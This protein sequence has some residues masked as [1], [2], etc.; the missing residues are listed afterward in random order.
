ML[1]LAVAACGGGQPEPKNEFFSQPARFAVEVHG[2][3]TATFNGEWRLVVLRNDG[4]EDYRLLVMG[5]DTPIEAPGWTIEAFVELVDFKGE[6]RYQAL[7]PIGAGQELL[8]NHA[9]VQIVE[10][11]AAGSPEAFRYERVVKP[12]R[13]QISREGAK[14]SAVCD[15]LA[16]D[17]EGKLV[18]TLR[19]SWEG[20]GPR[21]EITPEPTPS[22]SPVSPASPSPS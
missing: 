16:A 4:P 19:M 6:G 17:Q 22:G 13:F 11:G 21:R 1:A 14:G 15:G 2:H 9:Y 18:V 12:C 7:P 8:V 10:R 5:T 20:F 3:R